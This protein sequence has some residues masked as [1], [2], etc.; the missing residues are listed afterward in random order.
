M[1]NFGFNL[2]MVCMSVR[3]GLSLG[4]GRKEDDGGV[5]FKE[6]WG[7]F[8]FVILLFVKGISI[9]IFEF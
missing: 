4:L 8:G 7:L 3:V 2:Y 6:R 5:E 9:V 1:F